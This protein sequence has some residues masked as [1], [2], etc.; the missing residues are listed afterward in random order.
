MLSENDAIDV[1][2][3]DTLQITCHS[4]L[5]DSLKTK[6]LGT[7]LL[8]SMVDP[9]MG[10]TDAAIFTQLHLS[11]TNH[12]FGSEVFVDS[13]VL[14]LGLTGYYGDTTTLQTVHVYELDDS[15]SVTSNYYQCSDIAAKS[16]DLANGYQFRPHP[17]TNHVVSTT[18]TVTLAKPMIRIPLDISFGNYLATIDS[19]AYD[20]PDA[21]KQVCHG[22]KICCESVTQDGAICYLTP[23]T[24]NLTQLQ[25]YYRET[26]SSTKQLR[27]YFY[28][29]SEDAYFNQYQHDYTMGSSE[30]TQQVVDG[31]ADLGQ[32]QFYLQSMGGVRAKLNF[33]NI[34]KWQDIL[35]PNTYLI[36]NEAKLIFPASPAI[37]DSSIYRAP[38]SLA[39]L[40]IQSDGSTSMVQDYYE[41]STYYGG[42]YSNANQSV[43][44]RIGEHL[45]RCIL[46]NLDSQGLYVSIEGA[47][48]NAQRWIVAGPNADKGLKCEIKYSIV[49]E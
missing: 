31:N 12:R 32:D 10:Q 49:K 2:Y 44:F 46:G 22:L 37:G 25:I 42:G 30:F 34:A 38:A 9:V 15:L 3:T 35:E 27:Y 33:P 24:N 20:S 41:G 11:S 4:V 13:I 6:G 8:G 14:Q 43:T 17:K 5:V 18:D 47:S 45:Q 29:T 19:A 48:Y 23:T 40:N 1:Y 36:I 28:I 7:V 26:P 16:I 21:F 39:L